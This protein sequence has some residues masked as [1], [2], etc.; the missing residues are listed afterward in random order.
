MQT[1]SSTISLH[2]R[3]PLAFLWHTIRRHPA[4]HAAVLASVFL[5]VLAGVAVQ[6]GLKSLIDIVAGG[7]AA[8]GN[9]VWGALAV[10]CGLIAADNLMWRAGGWT[11][12]HVF[13]RVT[14]DVRGELFA[15][16]AGHSP[17]Y[18]SERL[19]GTLASRV[20][21][22]SNAVF[23]ISNIGAWNVLPPCFAVAL[24][25]ALIT[26]VSPELA[27]GLAAASLAMA[28]LVFHLARR[29]IPLHRL[30]ATRAAG[31]DGELVDV[32]SNMHVVRAFGARAREHSRILGRIGAE[33]AARR[34]SLL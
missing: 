25:I 19:P 20:T 15:H 10:L 31:V 22:T 11:A 29:G 23:Q 9:A 1:T 16:L 34:G 33:M 14:G 26:T 4:A 30:F 8:A 32:I 17:S 13:V 7:P 24:S 27:A 18:F 6:Y 28:A 12:A 5:A 3:R 2:Q 21:A